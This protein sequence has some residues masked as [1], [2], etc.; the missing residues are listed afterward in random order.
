[1][2]SRACGLRA[3]ETDAGEELRAEGEQTQSM[4]SRT[5]LVVDQSMSGNWYKLFQRQ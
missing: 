4:I 5:A 3:Q 2:M 1:M